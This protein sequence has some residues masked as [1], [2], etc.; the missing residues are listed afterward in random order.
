[1]IA[2]SLLSGFSIAAIMNLTMKIK[3]DQKYMRFTNFALKLVCIFTDKYNSDVYVCRNKDGASIFI[4]RRRMMSV[5][6]N[7]ILINAAL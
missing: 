5:F 2:L 3:K 4:N 1:M 7:K 6:I